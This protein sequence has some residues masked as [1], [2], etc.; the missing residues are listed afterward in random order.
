MFFFFFFFSSRRRHTRLQGDW[1]SDVCSS[2]LS[3]K[4]QA[5][6]RDFRRLESQQEIRLRA[7]IG[8][9]FSKGSSGGHVFLLVS[10]ATAKRSTILEFLL[11]AC[12]LRQCLPARAISH[13]SAGAIVRAIAPVHTVLPERPSAL[14]P[15]P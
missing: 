2:D 3:G 11:I 9:D 15:C 12:R 10:R 7:K 13:F 4:I 8:F 14:W 6:L 5:L 1:S